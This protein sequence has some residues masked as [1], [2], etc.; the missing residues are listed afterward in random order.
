[1]SEDT[2]Y[3]TLQERRWNRA[4]VLAEV[5]ISDQRPR[6]VERQAEI[7]PSREPHPEN[8]DLPNELQSLHRTRV[9]ND[10][11]PL[12]GPSAAG[13]AGVPAASQSSTSNAGKGKQLR[14]KASSTGQRSRSAAPRSI[15]ITVC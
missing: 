10:A 1:M 8:F 7:P 13:V 15:A 9:S 14:R 11:E 4:L 6:N 12:A 2:V 5:L 3:K